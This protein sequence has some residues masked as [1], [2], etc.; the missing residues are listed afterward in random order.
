MDAMEENCINKDSMQLFSNERC[1][2]KFDDEY[3]IRIENIS[4]DDAELIASINKIVMDL[5]NMPISIKTRKKYGNDIKNIYLMVL[6][7]QKDSA[8]EYAEK[9]KGIMERNL[10]L[11]R[12]IQYTVPATLIF[13]SIIILSYLLLSIKVKDIYYV[14][15]FS[16]LGGIL[17]LIYQQKKMNIDYKVDLYI[18]IIESLKRVILTLV[19]G[20][21]AYVCLKSNIIFANF[22]INSNKYFMFLILTIC[23]YSTS[24]IPN[25]LDKIIK[26]NEVKEK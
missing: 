22:N 10:E 5:N 23:G 19:L 4:S 1:T 25:I 12:M 21:V 17:S 6:N 18:I 24:F 13:L 20:C 26:T 11:K 15:I 14:C 3:K 8:K 7:N 16:C 9:L 2:I